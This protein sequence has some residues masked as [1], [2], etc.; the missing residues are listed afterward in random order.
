MP[1]A[2]SLS[3]CWS[4]AWRVFD[5]TVFTDKP[6][7]PNNKLILSF[8]L[9]KNKCAWFLLFSLDFKD[10]SLRFARFRS[11]LFLRERKVA[12]Q[13]WTKPKEKGFPSCMSQKYWKEMLSCFRLCT[14]S[15]MLLLRR[16]QGCHTTSK[17]TDSFAKSMTWYE[18]IW[19]CIIVETRKQEE[20]G[21][22]GDTWLTW[23]YG[24]GTFPDFV[25]VL[26]LAMS[27]N[28]TGS[29]FGD[30]KAILLSCLLRSVG[31]HRAP[32][33]GH[34]KSSLLT[35]PARPQAPNTKRPC[36]LKERELYWTLVSNVLKASW[37]KNVQSGLLLTKP[38]NEMMALD[39]MSPSKS[40][41]RDSTSLTRTSL[42]PTT[43]HPCLWTWFLVGDQDGVF[44]SELLGK[45]PKAP[46][47]QVPKE[48]GMCQNWVPQKA[49]LV[50]GKMNQKLLF[51][52]FSF[53]FIAKWKTF[54]F[55]APCP[56]TQ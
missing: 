43:P 23:S 53:W 10:M 2:S 13:N 16:L 42:W 40:F 51:P 30:E 34:K 6:N 49:L 41:Y 25:D 15:F 46:F 56:S 29:L 26:H 54:D 22:K 9:G 18:I 35:W 4:Q 19:T 28:Q 50:E 1:A 20:T 12:K 21:L 31:V 38:S 27:Q 24:R 37:K 8:Q 3:G 14:P 36:K 11:G 55:G 7:I 45:H 47:F 32:L 17:R 39:S 48:M 33:L 52:R 5:S 44:T